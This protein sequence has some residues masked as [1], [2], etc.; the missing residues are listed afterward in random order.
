[1]RLGA[2]PELRHCWRKK[3]SF[4]EEE[5]G[6]SNLAAGLNT[7]VDFRN[8]HEFQKSVSFPDSKEKYNPDSKEKKDILLIYLNL[9]L[10]TNS[11]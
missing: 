2:C 1:L 8:L 10:L 7:Q 11:Q 4:R 5:E 6:R 3:Q 9:N